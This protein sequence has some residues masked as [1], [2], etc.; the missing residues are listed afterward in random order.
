[1]RNWTGEQDALAYDTFVKFADS[2][3]IE[4]AI[5][6]MQVIQKAGAQFGQTDIDAWEAKYIETDEN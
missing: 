2:Y 3:G 5:H 1:M 6:H 4:R